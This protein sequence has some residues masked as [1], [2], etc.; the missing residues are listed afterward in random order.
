[1]DALSLGVNFDS[2]QKSQETVLMVAAREGSVGM[3]RKIIQHGANMNLTN[4]VTGN[5]TP[6]LM[7]A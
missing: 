4:K 1:V 6:C 5:W 3:V 2:M 7:F